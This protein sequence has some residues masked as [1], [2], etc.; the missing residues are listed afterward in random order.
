MDEGELVERLSRQ[1]FRCASDTLIAAFEEDPAYRTM[2]PDEATRVRVHAALWPAVVRYTLRWGEGYSASNCG[3]I[4]LWLPP[5]DTKTRVWRGL[6]AGLWKAAL[7]ADPDSRRYF[8]D[9]FDRLDDIHSTL[10]A[11]AHWYLWVLGVRPELQHQGVGSALLAP[12]LRRAESERMP[13]YLEAITG[14]NVGFYEHRG[15]EVL[16]SGV[17][18]PRGF[19]YWCMAKRPG[20]SPDAGPNT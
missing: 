17:L 5:G 20:A 10:M 13:I 12:M 2:F 15:F 19:T 1:Q 3:G 8:L 9:V 6:R 14:R 16:A 4:A 18:P 7:A 11:D